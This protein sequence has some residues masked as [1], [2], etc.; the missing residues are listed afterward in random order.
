MYTRNRSALFVG[1][2]TGSAVT[3]HDQLIRVG[4][5]NNVLASAFA[6][7]DETYKYAESNGGKKSTHSFLKG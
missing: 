7:L 6:T 5:A 4:K 3:E 2:V 1:R